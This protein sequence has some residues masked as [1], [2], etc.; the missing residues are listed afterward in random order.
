MAQVCPAGRPGPPKGHSA[1]RSRSRQARWPAGYVLQSER[2]YIL[3]MPASALARLAEIDRGMD[4]AP[5]AIR[6][7]PLIRAIWRA[8][9]LSPQELAALAAKPEG[10]ATFDRLAVTLVR[11]AVL[12][13][14]RL[15]DM[16]ANM[17]EGTPS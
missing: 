8:L 3:G 10:L 1:G 2:V 16:L 4:T 15:A 6:Y 12:G 7:R 9:L 17:V 5:P 14:V 13:D 11:R